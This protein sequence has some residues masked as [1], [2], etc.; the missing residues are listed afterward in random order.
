VGRFPTESVIKFC[1]EKNWLSLE[2]IHWRLSA[3]HGLLRQL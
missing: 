1:R 3:L 2:D